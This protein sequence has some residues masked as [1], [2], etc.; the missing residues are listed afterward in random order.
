MQRHNITLRTLTSL[1]GLVYAS[2]RR[3]RSRARR[4]VPVLLKP[5]P[6]KLEPLDPQR[7]QREVD[8]LLHRRKRSRGTGALHAAF[9]QSLSRR[10]IDAAITEARR[11][12]VVLERSQI[13]QIE[14]LHPNLVWAIDD[15]RFAGPE[16]VLLTVR[17]LASRFTF[18]PLAGKLANGEQVAAHL[19]CLLRRHG[20]PLL[21]KRDN[22]SN[23]NDAAVNEVLRKW[24]ILPLNSPVRSPQYNGAIENAQKDWDRLLDPEDPEICNHLQLHGILAAH[25]LNHLPRQVLKGQVPCAIFHGPARFHFN[26]QQRLKAL[27][28]ITD[29]A[30]E[31]VA[32]TGHPPARAWRTAVLIWLQMNNL[33]NIHPTKVSPGSSTKC[34]H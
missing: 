5:G 20:R 18:A 17:D 11:A 19:D 16:G 10:D 13:H 24:H 30:L 12:H 14:W 34:A 1:I 31:I 2:V 3:W 27:D 28:S 4:G 8:K 26:N 21:L 9:E 33:I 23:L 6:S 15:T 25:T 29:Y 22:G 7:F 32:S